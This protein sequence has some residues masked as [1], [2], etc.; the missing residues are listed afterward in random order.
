MQNGL[1]YNNSDLYYP[2]PAIKFKTDSAATIK[3][4]WVAG[5]ANRPLTI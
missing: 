1:D 3:V 4:W 5:D 2:Y